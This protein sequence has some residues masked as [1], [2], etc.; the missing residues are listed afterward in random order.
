MIYTIQNTSVANAM[1]LFATAPLVAAI[2]G[3]IVLRETAS[4]HLALAQMQVRPN[5]DEVGGS[6]S[7]GIECAKVQLSKT[8]MK[9]A[10][11]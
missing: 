6:C 4:D 9:G 5:A 8:A 7:T 1:L 11:Q 10:T 3:W 2:L